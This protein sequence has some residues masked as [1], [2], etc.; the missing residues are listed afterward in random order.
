MSIIARFEYIYPQKS[1]YILVLERSSQMNENHRWDNLHRSVTEFMM[2]MPSES[3]LSIISFSKNAVMHLPPTI[4]TD[5]NRNG[6]IGRLPRR[7]AVDDKICLFC[8]F[9]VT[10][11]VNMK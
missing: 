11:K 8:A 6:I 9:N 5:T 7:T 3:E 10:F 1:R 4:V 2:L